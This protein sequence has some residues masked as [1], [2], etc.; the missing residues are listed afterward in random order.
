MRETQRAKVL[1]IGQTS[2]QDTKRQGEEGRKWV[3]E[4]YMRLKK[5]EVTE[6]SEPYT[7]RIWR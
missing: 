3:W 4:G 1:K 5:A 2:A 7:D 6:N